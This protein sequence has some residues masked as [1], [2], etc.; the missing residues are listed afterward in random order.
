MIVSSATLNTDTGPDPSQGLKRSQDFKVEARYDLVMPEE[1][2]QT[3]SLRLL[4]AT[5]LSAGNNLVEV[6]VRR[7]DD[8]SVAIVLREVDVRPTPCP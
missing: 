4:D 8:G 6:G 1:A 2:R 5:N 7:L 3:Y